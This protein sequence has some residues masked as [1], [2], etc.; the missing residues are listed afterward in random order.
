MR[1]SPPARSSAH[2]CEEPSRAERKAIRV[3]S[4]LHR[5]RES[6][7]GLDVIRRGSPPATGTSQRSVLRLPP[8]RS[9]SVSA[10]A[11]REPS[12][13]TCGSARRWSFIISV[14]VKVRGGAWGRREAGEAQGEKG[15]QV[16][17]HG[18]PPGVSGWAVGTVDLQATGRFMKAAVEGQPV[19]NSHD[20]RMAA[21]AS[22]RG[23]SA[24]PCR[25]K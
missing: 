15:G 8:A 2:T 13:E 3:P 25:A 22:S 19:R 24:K 16:L 23:Q 20:S 17:A 4:G 10:K 11:T 14:A 12:G 5:G 21:G 9:T 1:G 6:E 7:A 18:Q